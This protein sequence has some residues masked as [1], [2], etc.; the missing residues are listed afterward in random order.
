MFYSI[1]AIVISLFLTYMSFFVIENVENYIDYGIG[2][3]K[4]SNYKYFKQ[5]GVDIDEVISRVEDEFQE[6]ILSGHS[7]IY[8]DGV[9]ISNLNRK[10][11]S[12]KLTFTVKKSYHGDNIQKRVVVVVHEGSNL[13][14]LK[15]PVIVDKD[16][17]IDDDLA[18]AR[19]VSSHA[20][21][22]IRD[23]S[24]NLL[25]KPTLLDKEKDTEKVRIQAEPYEILA[26]YDDTISEVE[27]V[28][29]MVS[30]VN[31]VSV[32][33]TK[34]NDSVLDLLREGYGKRYNI[35]EVYNI[36]IDEISSRDPTY[37]GRLI[38][39]WKDNRKTP[40]NFYIKDFKETDTGVTGDVRILLGI[41]EKDS[42]KDDYLIIENNYL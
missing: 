11:S 19:G 15:I 29:Y 24:L 14:A 23:Y 26:I 1:V 42:L 16:N 10:Y 17:V 18:S 20:A 8:G 34:G 9:V 25:E 40:F 37:S 35:D 30:N 33:K 38:V 4:Q 41:Y 7:N 6:Y 2:A 22:K 21:L 12:D 39:L 32:K 36:E 27:P 5:K 13:K 31:K 28:K 3:E